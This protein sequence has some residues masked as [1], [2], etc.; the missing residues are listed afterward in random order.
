LIFFRQTLFVERSTC[1]Y[2][3]AMDI[4]GNSLLHYSYL[5]S[6]LVVMEKSQY[7][8]ITVCKRLITIK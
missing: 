8:L 6:R 3:S 5:L 4:S 1:S 7:S 2:I